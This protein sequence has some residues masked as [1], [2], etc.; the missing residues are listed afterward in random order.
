[1]SYK[2]PNITEVPDLTP[3]Q[4][5]E[6]LGHLFEPCPTLTNKIVSL[7]QKQFPSYQHLIELIRNYLLEYVNQEEA[8]ASSGEVEDINLIIAAHPRLG[9]SSKGPSEDLSQHLSSEQKSLQGSPQE[10]QR[11]IELNDKYEET[12]PGLRYVVF[13]N[14]RSRQVIM[15]DMETRIEKNNIQAERI[16]AMNAMCDIALDRASKLCW[17]YYR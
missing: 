3:P 17:K 15:E 14:G 10:T 4:Q 5:T 13:V 12:F 2:L 6:L 9:G 1:M 7:L 8:K 16:H 11:L